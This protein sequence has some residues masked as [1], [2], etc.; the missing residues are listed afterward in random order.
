MKSDFSCVINVQLYL[1][2][3]TDALYFVFFVLSVSPTLFLVMQWCFT[4]YWIVFSMLLSGAHWQ[5]VTLFSWDGQEGRKISQ[6]CWKYVV[7]AK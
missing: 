1:R 4:G 3:H 2:D 7:V 5:T 6:P